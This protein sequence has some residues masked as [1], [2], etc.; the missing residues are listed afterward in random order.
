MRP[1]P[2]ST[3]PNSN[4]N[5]TITSGANR[6]SNSI[7]PSRAIP[8]RASTAIPAHTAAPA[9][10]HTAAH[11]SVPMAAPLQ[12]VVLRQQRPHHFD[13]TPMSFSLPL[14]G[15]PPFS[16]L[17]REEPALS[18]PKG[19]DVDSLTSPALTLQFQG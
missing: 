17:V 11:R 6:K 1:P 7:A 16:R 14:P 8:I 4:P 5:G 3:R 9:V 2:P 10:A 12:P 13:R 18:L 15:A 19:G